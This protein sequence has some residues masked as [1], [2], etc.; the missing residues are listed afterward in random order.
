MRIQILKKNGSE[1][2]HEQACE[3]IEFAEENEGDL[4]EEMANAYYEMAFNACKN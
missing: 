4:S 2:C 1:E 3:F